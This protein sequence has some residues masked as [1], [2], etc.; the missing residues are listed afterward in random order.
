MPT[1]FTEIHW[2]KGIEL[3]EYL[4]PTSLEEAL[5]MLTEFKGEARVISGGTDVIVRMRQ[6]KE[7]PRA[8]VDITGLPSLSGISEE[9]GRIEIGALVTH[10]QVAGSEMIQA[11]AGLL[12]QGCGAV[13]SPQIR[14]VATLAGNL[15]SGQPAA[16][17]SIPLLALGADVTIVS[18]ESDRVVPLADFF[19][20]VGRTALDP[21]REIMTKISFP[22]L[23]ENQGGAFKRL[24]K[25]KALTLPMLA[26]GVV[27][28]VDPAKETFEDVAIA[29]GPVA[30]TPFRE[31]GIEAS[32]V[33]KPVDRESIEEAVAGLYAACS[34]RDSLLRGSCDYRQEMV[35]VFV[36]RG[37]LAALTQAG[38]AIG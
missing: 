28:K 22:A 1:T 17:G 35:K 7:E 20:G 3:G 27:V 21:T 33:G 32:L 15:I 14:N 31:H 24:A 12:A 10:G 25:R 11:K 29:L 16:D 38:C 23:G 8:L 2:A 5:S 13:G 9:N 26:C 37:L 19:L 30:P 34:P 6:R 4:R 18:A 36:R